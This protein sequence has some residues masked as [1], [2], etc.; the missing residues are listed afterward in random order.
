MHDRKD[1]GAFE[2]VLR[3]RDRVGKKPTDVRVAAETGRNAGP[4][5]SVNF[6]SLQ[7]AREGS[8][9]RRIV[10]PYVFRQR[11]GDLLRPSRLLE[12]T[13]DPMDV[14]RFHAV[15]VF[16]DCSRPHIGDELIF[17]N[18]DFLTFELRRSVV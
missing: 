1:S 9:L 17:A 13:S 10:E 5:K 16:E 14:G 3:R 7:H 18:V 4:D 2:I 11:Y 15:I 6:A 8:P 12:P